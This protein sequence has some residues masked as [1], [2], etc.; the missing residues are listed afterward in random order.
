MRD[1]IFIDCG[2]SRRGSYSNKYVLY[3]F[4]FTQSNVLWAVCSKNLPL[5]CCLVPLHD[6]SLTLFEMGGCST[7]PTVNQPK[8]PKNSIQTSPNFVTFLFKND[9]SENK[10]IFFFKLFFGVKLV[11]NSPPAFNVDVFFRPCRK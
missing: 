8:D 6:C 7:P 4:S 9:L 11:L 1:G 2:L 10:K 5:V 3:F